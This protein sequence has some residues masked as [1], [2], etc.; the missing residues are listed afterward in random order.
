MSRNILFYL[1]S[2]NAGIL[3]A[4]ELNGKL[5][6]NDNIKVDVAVV[7]LKGEPFKPMPLVIDQTKRI[8][9][10]PVYVT[11]PGA[12]ATIRNSDRSRHNVF[13]NN[14][15]L[16]F[17]LNTGILSRNDSKSYN[18]DWPKDHI[19]RVGCFIHSTMTSYVI[20]IES[21][22]YDTLVFD[23]NNPRAPFKVEAVD[24][25]FAI[26]Y[27]TKPKTVYVALPYRNVKPVDYRTGQVPLIDA[28]SNSQIGTITFQ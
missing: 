9:H 19:M 16:E 25:P 17:K 2:L 21:N 10:E 23:N 14:L 13:V 6:L 20:N 26:E 11:Q 7:Y 5:T 28:D 15:Q 24:Y 12:D 1:I 4:A 27:K 22:Q 8:F 18:V 3:N